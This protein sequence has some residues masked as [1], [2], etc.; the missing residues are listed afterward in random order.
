VQICT[1]L[2]IISLD[3]IEMANER[4]RSRAW[5][6]TLNNYTEDD[7]KTIDGIK[8]RYIIVGKEVGKQGTPHLQG[9]IYFDNARSFM[10]MKKLHK[11]AH[12]EP[13]RGTDIQNSKYC[14]KEGNVIIHRGEPPQQGRRNITDYVD[15]MQK[16]ETTCEDIMF[17]NPQLYN[18]Y[19][20]TLE[21]I[22]DVILC[23]TKRKEMTRGFWLYGT[24]GCGKT[25]EAYK[26]AGDDYY[27][28]KNDKEWQDDY[29]G[30][31]NVIIDDFRG[32]IPY[33]ELLKMLD[34]HDNFYVSRRGRRPV[35][36]ISKNV[37]IT[38]SLPPSQ[39]YYNLSA[40][41]K[42]D[43]LLRR[44]EIKEMK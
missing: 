33:N 18:Q 5:C 37:Y 41:D 23:K 31:K 42:L 22:E 29:K 13:A 3:I 39:V 1:G 44:I 16:R 6:L 25:V 8:C 35:P 40:N 24:T 32:G 38:S 27:V 4:Q 12:W 19:G 2:R 30:Q 7:I 36:F 21:K 28:W 20:R 10:K 15:A 34:G 9:Y 11:S 43:Q 17:E 14:S 26:Q